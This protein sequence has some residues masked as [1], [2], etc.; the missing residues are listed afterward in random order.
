MT[1]GGRIGG[2][3]RIGGAGLDQ[4]LGAAGAAG[5]SRDSR[6]AAPRFREGKGTGPGGVHRGG[7]KGA[8]PSIRSCNGR[9]LPDR[10]GSAGA[11]SRSG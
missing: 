2:G 10:A 5:G 6:G 11:A 9:S 3:F 4:R 7:N 8:T 1:G